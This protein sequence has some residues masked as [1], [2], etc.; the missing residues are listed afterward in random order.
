MN[1]TWTP[2]DGEPIPVQFGGWAPDESGVPSAT[3]D[4]GGLRICAWRDDEGRLDAV[5][6]N[7]VTGAGSIEGKLAWM[8]GDSPLIL[9]GG[10]GR[11]FR[12]GPWR[13]VGPFPE[14]AV[15]LKALGVAP[16]D[17]L[18]VDAASQF[19]DEWPKP[20]V[21]GSPRIAQAEP[22][23][24]THPRDEHWLV[25]RNWA[26]TQTLRPML[27]DAP[28]SFAVIGEKGIGSSSLWWNPDNA[29]SEVSRLATGWLVFRDP[30]ARWL[31]V[32]Y[33]QM[34]LSRPLARDG[35][36]HGEETRALGYMLH[37]LAVLHVTLGGTE[38]ADAA[39]RVLEGGPYNDNIIHLPNATMGAS[40]H[41]YAS[42]KGARLFFALHGL[43][44]QDSWDALEPKDRLAAYVVALKAA[45]G[46]KHGLTV[47]AGGLFDWLG[48]AVVVWQLGIVAR[49][50]ALCALAI[51]HGGTVVVAQQIVRR[52]VYE[53]L[54]VGRW[55]GYDSADQH[56]ALA[57]T[58][59]DAYQARW[60]GH[61]ERV[62][63]AHGGTTLWLVPALALAL[64]SNALGSDLDAAARELLA[65]IMSK[66]KPTDRE[67][68]ETIWPFYAME[69]AT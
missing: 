5:V 39:R 38:Y 62:K 42:P 69:E 27:Y 36:W 56:V 44:Y 65:A 57:V 19:S 46:G 55:G 9:A 25:V 12:F 66:A 21:A 7:P 16:M 35:D 11:V 52:C 20:D 30:V 61:K 45:D 18:L 48:R 34:L 54:G 2:D 67:R 31:L 17:T 51:D 49:G 8:T 41:G 1:I 24:L 10:T 15:L 3:A 6:Y 68:V 23:W 47:G 4:A 33:G 43:A 26:D 14:H 63:I 32:K 22:V 64:R 59:H 40:S 37:D 53:I 29:H 50:A 13:T 60:P 28:D 58:V